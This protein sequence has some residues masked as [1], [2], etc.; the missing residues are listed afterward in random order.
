MCVFECV[1][2]STACPGQ[3]APRA[4]LVPGCWVLCVG[5]GAPRVGAPRVLGW[6]LR[7]VRVCVFSRVIVAR[8]FYLRRMSAQDR[9]RLSPH[10][11]H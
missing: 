2:P 4:P 11:P 9:Q 1:R 6:G 10:A 3:S 5:L 7:P 8:V